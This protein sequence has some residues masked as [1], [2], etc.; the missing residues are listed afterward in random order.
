MNF[1][2]RARTNI[3]SWIHETPLP[4]LDQAYL[5]FQ[6]WHHF[7]PVH[8]WSPT[9]S[10][11][12]NEPAKSTKEGDPSDL[13]LLTWNI[14]AT[15][16]RTQERVTEIVTFITGLDPK[17]HVVFLQDVSRPALQQILNDDR[18]R[19]SWFSSERDDTS[20]RKQSFATMILV[21]KARFALDSDSGMTN[22]TLGPIWR[23]KYPSHFDRDALCCDIFAI[24]PKEPRPSSTTRIRLVNVHLDSLP[25][26]PSHRPRQISIVSAFLRT[27]GR[28]L[29]AGDFNPVLKDDA[30]L[31]EDSGLMDVWTSLHSDDPGYTWG[32]GGEQPFP[33]NRLDKVAVLGLSPYSIKTLKPKRL[34]N[35]DETKS[36]QTER[37]EE[38]P[39]SD[40]YALLCS[41]G[42][43]ET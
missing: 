40:H 15:S 12:T 23:V 26:N 20:W 30:T 22:A 14:D 39:W 24:S 33:P 19:G 1:F 17:V 9:R 36:Q 10:N 5:K 42:L 7:D 4:S 37:T 41:V 16:P 28:G 29:V 6:S 32:V 18:I 35:L 43:F 38:I 13:V 34:G 8:Q 31:I 25:M 27:A 3:L 11:N 21:S 2:S